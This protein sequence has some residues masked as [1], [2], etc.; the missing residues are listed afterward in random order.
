MAGHS[1]VRW[2]L[3]L[4]LIGL[5]M[6]PKDACAFVGV[7]TAAP[8]VKA[9]RDSA[10]KAALVRVTQRGQ[11]LLLAYP[12]YW[13]DERGE[14]ILSADFEPIPRVPCNRLANWVRQQILHHPLAALAG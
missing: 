13:A 1:T 6:A 12:D 2:D 11:T 8:Y 14:P 7:S 9:S 3:Y 5:G 4:R 10:F